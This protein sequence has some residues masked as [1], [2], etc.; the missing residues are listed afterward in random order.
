M[1]AERDGDA[2]VTPFGAWPLDC[3]AGSL[4]QCERLDLLIYAERLECLPDPDGLTV[5]D[6]HPMG[7]AN[8]VLLA[9]QGGE[10]ITAQTAA[11]IDASSG[12]RPV[13]QKGSV[14][15]FACD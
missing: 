3:V 4:P 12:I 14:L 5:R 6:V 11:A 9:S 13:P 8:R 15:A 2:L 1:R 10:E 7:S